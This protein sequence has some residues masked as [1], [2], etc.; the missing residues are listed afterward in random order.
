MAKL[1]FNIDKG[2][3]RNLRALLKRVGDSDVDI[4]QLFNTEAK[5]TVDKMQR[6]APYDT[7]RLRRN[8]DFVHLDLGIE[9]Y[10]EAIDPDDGKDY[11]PIQENGGRFNKPQRFFWPN[12]KR[13]NKTIRRKL[14]DL[15]TLTILQNRNQ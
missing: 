6:K 14:G 10:S 7:G 8:T 9:F 1:K 12:I 11:A 4:D 5:T 2:S 13:F 15:I 3:E